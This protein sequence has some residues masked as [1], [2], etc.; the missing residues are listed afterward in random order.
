[1]WEVPINSL[2]VDANGV[3]FILDFAFNV[4]VVAIVVI[5]ADNFAPTLL[6]SLLL[7]FIYWRD[8]AA[9]HCLANST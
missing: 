6:Q 3:A 5:V 9:D 2:R 4:A 7:Y 8:E 1:M